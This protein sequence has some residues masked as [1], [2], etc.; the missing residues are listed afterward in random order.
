MIN[1]FL[2][3]LPIDFLVVF[4]DKTLVVGPFA[5]ELSLFAVADEDRALSVSHGKRKYGYDCP[6]KVR[7]CAYVKAWIRAAQK[8][9]NY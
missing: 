2:F 9:I 6:A 1:C 8:N 3:K 5:D 4:G 7:S